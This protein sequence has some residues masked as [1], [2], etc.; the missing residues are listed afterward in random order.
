MSCQ[1]G[2][3]MEAFTC[4]ILARNSFEAEL[5]GC[6]CGLRRAWNLNFK[7]CR[8]W[9]YSMEIVEIQSIEDFERHE[10]ADLIEEFKMLLARDWRVSLMWRC[11]EE[12]ACADLLAKRAI[13]A[14]GTWIA[15]AKPG[16]SYGYSG[17]TRHYLVFSLIR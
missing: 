1:D 9:T 11:R 7:N 17:A 3:L 16:R 10:S 14:F 6:I 5:W 4:G 12:N 13:Y 8:L 15:F 2:R